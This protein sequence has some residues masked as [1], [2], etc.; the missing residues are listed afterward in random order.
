MLENG[1]AL[2]EFSQT[3]LQMENYSKFYDDMNFTSALIY[4]FNL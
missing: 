2:K 3:Q 4:F 1:I